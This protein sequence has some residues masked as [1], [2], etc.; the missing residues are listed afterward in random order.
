MEAA[1]ARDTAVLTLYAFS[2]D[3]WRRPRREVAAL[4]R[5]FE[6]H[7]IE[8]MDR[9]VSHGVRVSVIGR[10]DRLK[11]SLVAAMAHVET[12]TRSGGGLH[13]R[14]AVDYSE[15]TGACDRS[16]CFAGRRERHFSRGDRSP[17]RI[18]G[19]AESHP[20]YP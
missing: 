16:G 4:M 19:Q 17:A 14:I 3:N 6:R 20:R 12:R 2:A 7:L 11:R 10:R 15:R 18:E 13:V 1:A 9:C 5:L 8:Q